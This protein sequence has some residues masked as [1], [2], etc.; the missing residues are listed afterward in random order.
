MG[1]GI[2]IRL[3]ARLATLAD[4]VFVLY[5]TKEF[6]HRNSQNTDTKTDSCLG[7]ETLMASLANQTE[8]G[9]SRVHLRTGAR[10]SFLL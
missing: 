3:Y 5:P 9:L 7:F 10:D 4:F 8:P 1:E 2:K 6:I